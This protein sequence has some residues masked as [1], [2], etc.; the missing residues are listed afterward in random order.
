MRT[1]A[2]FMT[3]LISLGLSAPAFADFESGLRAY[4]AGDYQT[5]LTEFRTLAVSGDPDAQ[6]ILALMYLEGQAVAMNM[7]EAIRWYA[8]AAEQGQMDAQYALALIAMDGAGGAARDEETAALWM[9]ES[10]RRGHVFA[11][12]DLGN[13]YAQ[14]DGVAQSDSDAAI[15]FEAAANQGH[16]DAQ[17][18]LGVMFLAGRGVEQDPVAAL[19]WFALAAEQGHR[20]AQYNLGISYLTGRN[21]EPNPAEAVRWLQAAADQ[22]QLNAVVAL[23]L[24]NFE[25]EQGVERNEELAAQ[26]FLRAAESGNAEGQY[27][28]A[29]LYSRGMGVE[30]NPVE[31]YAWNDLASRR[32][33]AGTELG[34][35]VASLRQS[36]TELMNPSEI[37][38]AEALSRDRAQAMSRN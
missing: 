37:A 24:L 17:Y 33:R 30:Q 32:V 21:T 23:G 25:G 7:A 28:L 5:A 8:S 3:F 35:R 22:D 34:N 36:L 16:R 4:E 1:F 18:N 9:Q 29:V 10:A 20:D 19:Q 11:Q 38:Q 31:A 26:L 13:M 15:W 12:F 14:G 6:T 27:F 2:I